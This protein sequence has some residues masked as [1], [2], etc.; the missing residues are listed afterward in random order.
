M[1]DTNQLTIMLVDLIGW[2]YITET[3][4]QRPMGGSQSAA[5]YLAEELAKLGHQIYL[6]NH[7]K[8]PQVSRGVQCLS[9]NEDAWKLMPS[10][11]AMVCINA[12][13]LEVLRALRDLGGKKP[14]LVLWT[15]HAADQ[16][17]IVGLKNKEIHEIIDKLVLVSSWQARQHID[18]F[19]IDSGRI[20][21][22]RNAIAPAFVDLF[23]EEPS[24]RACK[25]HP[26]VLAYTSTPFRGLDVLLHAFP[27]IR[28][29]IPGTTLKVFSDMSIY[30]VPIEQDP[31][32]DLYALCRRTEGVEYIGAVAQA[33]LAKHLKSVTCL[34][35]PSTFAETS[36]ISVMEALAAGCVVVTTNFG[37]LPETTAGMA[38]LVPMQDDLPALARDFALQTIEVLQELERLPDESER[39]LREQ[40]AQV[41]KTNTWALRAREWVE[42]LIKLRD[43]KVNIR[44]NMPET[45]IPL[46]PPGEAE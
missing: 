8:T 19:H 36:C 42:A 2:D 13:Q 9:N 25:R 5:C 26:P 33:D 32:S 37:A 40:I 6:L 17:A 23:S 15:G 34:A 44:L 46:P 45:I 39:R 30:Q 27:T 24:V 16:P 7:T 43:Q 31:F 14:L 10:C 41:N 20:R 35:Y 11:D 18:A 12:A 38:R 22:L 1:K 28:H 4:Y 3:P 21:V 29:A